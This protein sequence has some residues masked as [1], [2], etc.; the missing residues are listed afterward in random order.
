MTYVLETSSLVMYFLFC[1]SPF[2]WFSISLMCRFAPSPPVKPVWTFFFQPTVIWLLFEINVWK[3]TPLFCEFL[4]VQWGCLYHYPVLVLLFSY[5]LSVPQPRVTNP[6]CFALC[7]PDTQS[8]GSHLAPELFHNTNLI[9][10]RLFA[11][12]EVSTKPMTW[13]VNRNGQGKWLG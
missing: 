8:L 4:D 9:I 1:E 13:W 5:L 10:V 2:L 3:V 6:G 11:D 12:H 7:C